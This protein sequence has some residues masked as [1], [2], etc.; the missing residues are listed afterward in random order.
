[1]FSQLHTLNINDSVYITDL[2]NTKLEYI[3]YDKF[4]VSENNLACT[5]ASSN[6]ELTLIT[7]NSTNNSE[8]IVI[9]AKVKG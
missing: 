2:N 5:K 6:I 3:I 4:K 7:C 9:K 8:R 1:M